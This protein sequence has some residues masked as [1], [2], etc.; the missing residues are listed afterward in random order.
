M[1][2]PA[3]KNHSQVPAT[4]HT[5]KFSRLAL[6]PHSR[7]LGADPSK[8]CGLQPLSTDLGGEIPII[9]NVWSDVDDVLDAITASYSP[10][11]GG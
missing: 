10:V 8:E 3:P 6:T 5:M 2:T 11:H 7:G 4:P 9:F 1:N